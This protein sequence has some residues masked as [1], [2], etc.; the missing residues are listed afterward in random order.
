LRTR[1][2]AH[3]AV[4]FAVAGTGVKPHGQASYDEPTAAAGPLSFAKGHDLMR[5]FLGSG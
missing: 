5:W 2:H 1:A 3:G 4:P